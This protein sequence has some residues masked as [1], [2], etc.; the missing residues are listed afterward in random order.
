MSAAELT[1]ACLLRIE[2]RNG[3][4]PSPDG[5]SD[6]I[7]AWVT[8][9]PDA[10]REQA[11]E[12]DRRLAREGERAPLLCGI[13]LALKDLYGVAGLPLT[14]SSRVLDGNVATR[15]ARVWAVLRLSLIHI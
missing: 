10:A 2:E 6:A 11:R 5:R 15:D 14:A 3:G 8:L 9:Y 12:A 7:N 1:A 13:P 4:P